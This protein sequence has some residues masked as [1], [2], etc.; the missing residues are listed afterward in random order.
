MMSPTL[1]VPVC[2]STVPTG[3][4]ALSMRASTIVP[5]AVRF[6]LAF[7]SWR[8]A[9]SRTMSTRSS[10]PTRVLAETGTS[11][12][13]PPYS[14]MTT[15]ASVSS[16][17]TRSGLASGLSILLSAMMIGTFA[18]LAWPIASSVWGMTP[19]SAATT[20]TAMSVTFAPRAR[21][22]VNASWPGVSR[23]TTRRSPRVTS[24]APMCCVM[25]PRSPAATVVERMASSRLVLPWSTWP[26]TVTIGARSTRSALSSS[27][28]SSSFVAAKVAS[29]PSSPATAAPAACGSATS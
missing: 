2:T 4:R 18:A 29:S 17:L 9:T 22:A 15:P 25:P 5:I 26:M 12:V 1:S 27:V 3:P 7:S 13:S 14:S 23:K 10:R 19:S 11:G 24:L 6:G 21:M 20:T 8:S 16:V 28:N